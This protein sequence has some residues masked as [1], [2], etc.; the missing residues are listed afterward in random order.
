MNEKWHRE[1]NRHFQEALKLYQPNHIVALCLQGS[2]NY[3]LETLNSD[4]DTKC[5]V[6]PSFKDIVLN[7]MP[8]STTHIL[9][10]NEHL[11]A[12][13]IRNYISCFRKQNLNFLEILFT[14]YFIINPMYI[15]SWNKLLDAREEIARMNPFRA[16]K[17]MKGVALEKYHAMEHEY[18]SKLDVLAKYGYDPKQLHHLVRVDHYLTRYINGDKYKD[19]LIPEEK[20]MAFLFD[21][22]HGYLDLDEARYLAELSLAHVEKVANEFCAK[23]EDKENEAMRELLEE[24]SYEIMKISISKEIM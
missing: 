20:M 13:D 18:P 21:I 8:V 17:S 10:N 23:H 24:V 15:N 12:K 14:D 6:T 7:K 1:V 19:C 2:Q 11:D 22:K 5:I 16:V 3:E 4:V 9:D